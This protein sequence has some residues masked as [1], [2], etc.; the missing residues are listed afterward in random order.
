MSRSRSDF[1]HTAHVLL[2]TI[3]GD[4]LAFIGGGDEQDPDGEGLRVA[5]DGT[6]MT[7]SLRLITRDGEVELRGEPEITRVTE[8]LKLGRRMAKA[9]GEPIPQKDWIKLQQGRP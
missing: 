4:T 5:Y 6:G 9:F 7:P 3:D 1:A 2:D 8:A